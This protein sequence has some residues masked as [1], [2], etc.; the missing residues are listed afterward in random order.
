MTTHYYYSTLIPTKGLTVVTMTAFYWS[1]CHH[2]AL[3][4]A[5]SLFLRLAPENYHLYILTLTLDCTQYL[6]ANCEHSAQAR[7]G[8]LTDHRRL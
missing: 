2:S 4:L 1:P 6:H 7:A 8:T 3:L 5:V